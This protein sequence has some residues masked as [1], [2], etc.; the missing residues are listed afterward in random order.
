MKNKQPNIAP[1][2]RIITHTSFVVLSL[3]AA[4]L[5]GYTLKKT[6]IVSDTYS[7][8][9]QNSGYSFIKPLLAVD[10]RIDTPSPMYQSLFN[11]I[12]NFIKKQSSPGD[13]TSVYFIDYGPNGG[14]FAIN[15]NDLYSPA[16][17]MKIVI[18]IAF[19]KKA[20]TDPS[21]LN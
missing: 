2:T 21:I 14:R 4:F 11:N 13:D 8:R 20:E 15:E 19:F 18:M 10:T 3:I 6:T 7:V 1:K 9:D 17:L 5:L 16:S 12:K